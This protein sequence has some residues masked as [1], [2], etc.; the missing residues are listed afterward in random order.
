[1]LKNLADIASVI[2]VRNN[3]GHSALMIAA[4]NGNLSTAK[5][6][7]ESGADPNTSDLAGS[8]VLMGAAF[9]G[10]LAMLKLLIDNG[11]SVKMH[12]AKNQTALSFAEMFEKKD[13]VDLLQ[14]NQ[15]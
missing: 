15:N 9:K 1:M 6:L 14:D 11:A 8:T 12:N 4:Y 5:F 2:N 3:N 10:D 13:A 7:L